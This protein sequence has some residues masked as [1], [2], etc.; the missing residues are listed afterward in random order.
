MTLFLNDVSKS[1]ERKVTKKA[2]LAKKYFKIMKKIYFCEEDMKE[3]NYCINREIDI[4]KDVVRKL[5][6]AIILN[7]INII[8]NLIK[9]C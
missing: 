1:F 3:I 5:I 4:P 9:C 8:K 6:K 7:Y 2:G